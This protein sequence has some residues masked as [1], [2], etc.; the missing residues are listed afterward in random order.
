[1]Y[2]KY[3]VFIDCV[4]KINAVS[5]NCRPPNLSSSTIQCT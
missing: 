2:P 4:I 5:K 3:D 1:M